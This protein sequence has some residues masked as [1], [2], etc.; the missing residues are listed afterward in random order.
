MTFMYGPE[1]RPAEDLTARAR[2]VDAALGQFAQRGASGATMRSIAQAAGVSVG[3]VQHHFGTKHRLRE[4]C[5][6]RVLAL[7]RAKIDL[8]RQE[9]GAPDLDLFRS[10]YDRAAPV[11]PYAA[12]AALDSDEQGAAMFDAITAGTADFFT[13]YD[14]EGY[15]QGSDRARDAAATMVAM[16]LGTTL[17]HHQLTRVMDLGTDGPTPSPRIGAA[18]LDVYRTIGGMVSA[19]LGTTVR[20]GTGSV[21]E[22]HE[23][24]EES[25]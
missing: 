2:I 19:P 9:G 7:V 5:N 22:R 20:D 1:E 15:P 23:T 21:P 18:A 14:P 3:L 17:L 4:A 10:L 12:R 25:P 6:E 24:E 8:A 16:S 13:E 11:L